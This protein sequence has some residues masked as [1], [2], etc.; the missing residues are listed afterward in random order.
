M[1]YLDSRQYTRFLEAIGAFAT[2][3]GAGVRRPGGDHGL[4][5]RVYQ[6]VPTLVYSRYEAVRRFE[7]V[8]SDAP[9]RTLHALRIDCKRFRYALEF[10]R[11]VLGSDVVW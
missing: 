4:P 5:D 2:T 6:V 7:P 10:F 11:E 9:L 1:A 8:I 3:P